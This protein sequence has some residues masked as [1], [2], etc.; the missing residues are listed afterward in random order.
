MCA[1]PV[2]P[3]CDDPRT[4]AGQP[5]GMYHCPGCGTMQMAGLP[6]IDCEGCGGTGYTGL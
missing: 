6:H 2:G 5:I 4:L 1:G 3:D